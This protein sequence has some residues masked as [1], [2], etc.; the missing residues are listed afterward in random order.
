[1]N[2]LVLVGIAGMGVLAAWIVRSSCGGE[3]V[4]SPEDTV[5]SFYSALLQGQ[6]E[7]AGALCSDSEEMTAYCGK[8][9]QAWDEAMK[10][11]PALLEAASGILSEAAMLLTESRR[12]AKDRFSAVL[13][14]TTD[15]GRSRTREVQLEKEGETWLVTSVGDAK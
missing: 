11:E 8:F 4:M 7:K 10:K 1:M 3:E 15:S 12:P 14:I 13:T 5:R 6:W 2:I 9:R